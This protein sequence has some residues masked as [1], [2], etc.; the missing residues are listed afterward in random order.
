MISWLFVSRVPRMRTV[1]FSS[2]EISHPPLNQESPSIP[3][4]K[5]AR[6]RNFV[7]FTIKFLSQET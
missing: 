2:A 7:V 3:L 1:L 6:G 5:K 4:W